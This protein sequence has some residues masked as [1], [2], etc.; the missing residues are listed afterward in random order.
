MLIIKKYHDYYDSAAN[1]G[2]DKT[3]VYERVISELKEQEIGFCNIHHARSFWST[4]VASYSLTSYLLGFCGKTYIIYLLEEG[5]D[6]KKYFHTKDGIVSW[7]KNYYSKKGA[8]LYG[9]NNDLK[10]I[11]ENHIKW[12]NKE[13]HDLFFKFKSPI[14]LVE[15]NPHMSWIYAKNKTNKVIINPCL[16]D[17][18]FFKV[19]DTYTAFQEIQSYIS[20]VLGTNN[21]EIITIS[22]K[23]KIVSHGFD[24]KWSFRK[25]PQNKK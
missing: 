14:F 3:I 4:M 21:K 24:P 12:D 9:L 6:T 16:K 5:N 1:V 25:E 23:D 22:D 10:K 11:E 18:E 2:I 17:Y 8:K 7:L 20:G 15:N 19:K 13:H